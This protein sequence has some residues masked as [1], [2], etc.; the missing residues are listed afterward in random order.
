VPVDL[1][2]QCLAAM[3]SRVASALEPLPATIKMLAPEISAERLAKIDAVI[4]DARN[5][6]ER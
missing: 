2:A 5:L 4:T 1:L 3:G 6:A